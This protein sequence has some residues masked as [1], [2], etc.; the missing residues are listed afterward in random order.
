MKAPVSISLTS[1]KNKNH[2]KNIFSEVVEFSPSCASAQQMMAHVHS[3]GRS[4]EASVAQQSSDN[5]LFLAKNIKNVKHL[6]S[7]TNKK[8]EDSSK[9]RFFDSKNFLNLVS[10]EK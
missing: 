10:V 7:R 5:T 9:K 6:L 1:T 2:K 4:L 8:S 3:L